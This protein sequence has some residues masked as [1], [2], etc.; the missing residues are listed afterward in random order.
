VAVWNCRADTLAAV[1]VQ[2]KVTVFEQAFP[3]LNDTNGHSNAWK[4]RRK[5]GRPFVFHDKKNGQP[6][7]G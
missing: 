6:A 2:G 5:P 7:A 1:I 3:L 4:T